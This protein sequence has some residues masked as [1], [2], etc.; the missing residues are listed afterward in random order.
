MQV[1]SLLPNISFD[2]GVNYDSNDYL[3]NN[4]WADVGLQVSMNL[5]KPLSWPTMKELHENKILND[6]ARRLSL[7]MA[8]LTQ[9]RLSVERYRLALSDLEIARE[10]SRVDQRLADYAKAAA[11]TRLEGQL[12]VIRAETRALNSAYQ[13]HAAYATAQ[14]AFGRIYNSV[15]LTVVPGDFDGMSVDELAEVVS[16][17]VNGVE[18]EIFPQP[19]QGAEPASTPAEA[20]QQSGTQTPAMD[21]QPQA[22]APAQV[23]L[24]SDLRP[25]SYADLSGGIQLNMSI[26]LL[27]LPGPQR[28]PAREAP[29][30][31]RD[32]APLPERDVALSMLVPS[33]RLAA[34]E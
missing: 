22:P 25:L 10:S 31:G 9:V 27:P 28:E 19:V 23:E 2:A 8:V 6:E 30:L 33:A 24:L 11:S 18:L 34:V 17:H 21:A 26:E 5:L 3:Y 12:E 4:T 32:D 16:E 13:R 29:A 14:A 1:L 15:G 20:P 7:S